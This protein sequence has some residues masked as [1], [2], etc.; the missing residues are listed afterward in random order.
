[1]M[2][3]KRTFTLSLS[4][5]LLTVLALLLA[6]CQPQAQP[7]SGPDP[8][9]V[10]ASVEAF[11]AETPTLP[12]VAAP[13]PEPVMTDEPKTVSAPAAPLLPAPLYFLSDVTGS[14][15]I[16]RI[17]MNGGYA[18]QV[19][20]L[21]ASVYGFDISPVDGR[22]AY[23]SGND[24]YVADPD[25]SNPQMVVNG[26]DVDPS[27]GHDAARTIGMPLWSPDGKEL[28]YSLNGVNV[29]NL[30]TNRVRSLITNVITGLDNV[31]QW[32]S[33][34]PSFWSPDGRYIGTQIGYYEGTGLMILP[35]AG[36]EPVNP[37]LYVCC[38]I[39]QSEDPGIFYIASAMHGYGEPGLWKVDWASGAVT[40][41]T[42]EVV[43]YSQMT[44]YSHPLL[45]EGQL[46]FIQSIN[47]SVS[48]AKS[49]PGNLASIETLVETAYFPMDALWSPD[50]SLV[51]V[52]G[53]R[54]DLPLQI[55]WTSGEQRR[56]EVSGMSLKW[57][58]PTEADVAFAAT[59]A[60]APTPIVIPTLP[61]SAQP[62]TVDNVTQLQVL[63]ALDNDEWVYSVAISPD[64]KL[65]A[66][67]LTNRVRIYD[68]QTMTRAAELR[69]YS[70][71]ITALDFSPDSRHLAVG[72]WDRSLDLWEMGSYEK[73]RSFDAHND[74]VTA[75]KFSPDGLF[76]ASSSNDLSM[77]LYDLED[78]SWM[79]SISTDNWV[80]DVDF[81]ADGRF[82]AAAA[83]NEDAYLLDATTG[84]VL[85]R[86]SRPPEQWALNLAFSP[87]SQTLV[88]GTWNYDV[89]LYDL[90]ARQER[91]VLYG[92]NDNPTGM[93]F[94]ADER[95]LA[96]ADEGGQ[97]RFWDLT[98]G[99]FLHEVRGTRILDISADGRLL[100][101]GGERIEGVVLWYVP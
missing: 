97:L 68:L 9:A 33:Y 6:A 20:D 69:P 10:A 35:A 27:L 26:E 54:P 70:D 4:I 98:N 29:F 41:L 63:T 12:T 84:A 38:D 62:I 65:L 64:G 15:Q 25:G 1:M 90:A 39:A 2:R 59:P 22:L 40:R 31:G 11:F 82:A 49:R 75:V 32:R 57:G 28:A 87:D 56:L 48:I 71:I 93:A 16:W 79:R 77:V 44:V 34:F 55:W 66:L 17:E 53:Q 67:G 3:K 60:P 46:Y 76:L 18:H 99:A 94:S 52:G 72:S 21:P 100:V 95:L 80:N 85:E 5:L 24:L 89:I 86:I 13:T 58:V 78:G 36:G 43:D 51:I 88:L 83:W 37:D 96:T 81:S 73:V 101:T 92:H 19:T 91:A 14:W 23:V 30:E 74:W 61:A 8:S 42:E 50:A 47:R 7:L 45:F